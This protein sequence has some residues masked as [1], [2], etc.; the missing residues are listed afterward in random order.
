MHCIY[1]NQFSL[2]PAYIVLFF[3]FQLMRTYAKFGADGPSQ[4]GFVPPSW[5]ELMDALLRG[6]CEGYSAIEPLSLGIRPLPLVRR[7]SP[8][9]LA[10]AC[11][12]SPSQ[13][14]F[15]VKTHQPK[16]KTV[17]K[18]LGL[19]DDKE[20]SNVAP[21]NELL[22]F[23][24]AIG[25]DYPRFTV[26][27][28]LVPRRGEGPSSTKDA[29]TES[30]SQDESDV[31]FFANG[32]ELRLPRLSL[33]MVEMPEILR[34]ME[35]PDIQAIMR[36]DSSGLREFDE[37][38]E[39]FATRHAVVHSGKVAASTITRTGRVAASTISKTAT[40]LTDIASEL[41]EKSGLH[42]VV[43]PI[44]HTIQRGSTTIQKGI[45][46]GISSSVH[47][48]QG[49]V[50]Q[51]LGPVGTYSNSLFRTQSIDSDQSITGT[52]SITGDSSAL[53]HEVG[54]DDILS[55]NLGSEDDAEM[56]PLL[57]FP[58]QNVDVEGPSTGKK[59]TEDI[60][61]I[62]EKMHEM[63]WNLFND[64]VSRRYVFSVP[65]ERHEHI[66]NI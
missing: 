40:G 46:S 37:E 57:V 34:H 39:N 32:D 4:Q 24:F 6:G 65:I 16:G 58:E 56:D 7:K 61:E 52:R 20:G 50:S 13:L 15:S 35:L 21:V 17:F 22:E 59:I 62:K 26:K 27:E 18:I 3:V 44:S 54:F 12:S 14:D 49:P 64:K 28:S 53:S 66:S 25:A 42:H 10:E 36:K 47:F 31:S 5:E 38:E 45:S 33:D 43:S 11:E 60:A 8:Q 41:T 2:V 9:S 1:A 29:I 48:V 19:T 51:V 63:T 23:P 55:S 30:K